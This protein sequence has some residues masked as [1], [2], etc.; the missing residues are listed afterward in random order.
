MD[1]PQ[2][3]ARFD[4]ELRYHD[5]ARLPVG[6]ERLGPAAGPVQSVHEPAVRALAQRVGGHQGTQLADRLPVAAEREQQVGPV[7]G[8]RDASLLQPP[9]VVPGA[10]GQVQPV[11]DGAAP[12]VESLPGGLGGGLQVPVRHEP[13]GRP[14]ALAEDRRVQLARV[15]QE[16]VAALPGQHPPLAQHAPELRHVHAQVV[17]GRA[18]RD[19]GPERVHETV[20][21]D[22]FPR[23]GD[24][25]RQQDPRL[26][27]GEPHPRDL[28]GTQ[29]RHISHTW[30]YGGIYAPHNPSVTP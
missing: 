4:A 20:V 18:R 7:L 29:H 21:G 6:V 28:D 10:L 27:S 26:R 30:L 24:Q 12:Q 16:H 19:A 11:E 25:R 22:R 2:L 23:G 14:L 9:R 3:V 5:P 17:D 13:Q 8:E 1:G 15:E